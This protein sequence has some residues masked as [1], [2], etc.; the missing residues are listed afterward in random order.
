MFGTLR[1]WLFEATYGDLA[2]RHPDQVKESIR[3]NAELGAKL[4]GADLARAEVAHTKLYER[5]VAFFDRY[6]VLLAPTTQVLPFPVELEY[7]TEI[8]G[9]P[10]GQLPGVDA[11]LHAHL[12]DRLPGAV[13]AGRLHRPTGC[14]SGC[15]SSARRGPTGG[16]SRSGTPSS[17]RPGSAT[18]VPLSERLYGSL[19]ASLDS[20]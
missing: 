15:R 20:R 16:C 18:A 2:R 19:A 9:V 3:W 13:G 5:M 1:A 14:R 6:D 7:P 12:G 8:G 11:L 17:R 4:T 10:A